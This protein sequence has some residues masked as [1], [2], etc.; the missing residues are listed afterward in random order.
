M[1]FGFGNG[2]GFGFGSF[3]GLA[4]LFLA[5]EQ[6]VIFDPS[7]TG[8]LYTTTAMT[9]PANPGDPVGMMLDQSQWGGAALGSLYGDELVTNGTFSTDVSGWTASGNASISLVSNRLRVTTNSGSNGSAY[10]ALSTV[11]GG[12]YLLS[13][14]QTQTSSRVLVGTSL[15]NGNILT[16][17]F[18]TGI[19]LLS[20]TAVGT[21]TFLT[22]QSAAGSAGQF[23][24]FDNVSVRE[25]TV[26]NALAPILGPEVVTN[27]D[28][29]SAT[30]WVLGAG[31]AITGGELVLTSQVTG[32][33]NYQ[34]YSPGAVKTL[35]YS[36]DITEYTAGAV[37]FYLHGGGTSGPS[38]SAVG[39]YT[40]VV[41][42]TAA[43][44][45]LAIRTSG[46]TTLKVDNVSVKEIPGY[47]ATQAT[48]AKRPTY[49]IHPFGGRRNLLTFSED[50][51]NA[52]WA[53]FSVTKTGSQTASYVGGLGGPNSRFIQ[54]SSPVPG[55]SG[56]ETITVSAVVSGTGKFRVKNS[57]AGVF[58]NFSADITLSVTP[59]LI[60][61]TVTNGA[62]AGTGLQN[63]GFA[64]A[65]TD[66][67]FSITAIDIQAELGP[68]RTAYQK[69]TSQY[70]V[71]ETGVPSVYY[72]AFDG[73][74][75]AMAT[76]SI[77]FTA[78][79]EMS[80]F[81]GVRKLAG[82][83]LAAVMELSPGAGNG[84]FGL[85]APRRVGAQLDDYGIIS[86]GTTRI[87]LNTEDAGYAAPHTAVM[88]GLADISAPSSTLRIN[89]AI[90]VSSAGS[91]GTGNYGNYPIYIGARDTTSLYF[92]GHLYGLTVRGK[93]TDQPTVA[94][95]EALGAAKTGI[96][97]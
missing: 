62:S 53:V 11:I 64:A 82:E 48:A 33:Q 51:T 96:S 91:Q 2:F 71:T 56:S 83:A 73:V 44:S 97:L 90:G 78:T 50:F 35:S 49:G 31:G 75:D 92:N 52:A 46:T 27:G 22:L 3:F 74:D 41:E 69:V 36:F 13:L 19:N 89:G 25:V 39:T 23:S 65:T 14:E 58:D 79:D 21:T 54:N 1:F 94:K 30:D 59:T 77:D 15:G 84:I 24:D 70:V 28:F 72:L 47:H 7:T 57:H 86:K 87:D 37:Q 42:T 10:Q 9:T 29:S 68:T 61:F 5:G 18:T 17:G 55:G 67:A 16:G 20:F 6:G 45:R 66:E 34:N 93:L 95:A 40:G 63:I 43:T 85:F 80:V 12:R 38:F 81:A 4:D 26:A 32:V 88:T 60:S 76:P 8:T